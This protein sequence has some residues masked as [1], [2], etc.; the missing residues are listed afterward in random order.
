M[1]TVSLGLEG[2]V[3][4]EQEGHVNIY[5]ALYCILQGSKVSPPRFPTPLGLDNS[6]ALLHTPTSAH[7]LAIIVLAPEEE[8]QSKQ[9]N[10]RKNNR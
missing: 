10:E 8:G 9:K 6:R 4:E 1:V 3:C 5:G 2:V 7:I